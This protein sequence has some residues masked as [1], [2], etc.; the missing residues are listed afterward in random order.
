[1]SARGWAQT[2]PSYPS[3][4]YV[5]MATQRAVD[6]SKYLP[7]RVRWRQVFDEGT[8]DD[9]DFLIPL[10]TKSP[11]RSVRVLFFG[12]FTVGVCGENRVKVCPL[13]CTG[14]VR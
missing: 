7:L 4:V 10:H 8:D 9:D 2:A 5:H 14:A 13:A 6:A 3:S 12:L 11:R 1:M